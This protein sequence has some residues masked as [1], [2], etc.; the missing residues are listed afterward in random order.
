MPTQPRSSCAR[1]VSPA[2]CPDGWRQQGYEI[3]SL[4]NLYE[5]IDASRL[6]RHALVRGSVGGRAGSLVLQGPEFLVTKP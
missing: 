1:P 2:G 3:V 6:P 4:G 5:S